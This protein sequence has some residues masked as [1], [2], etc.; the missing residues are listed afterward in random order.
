MNEIMI[1]NVRHGN[2]PTANVLYW[3]YVIGKCSLWGLYC[4]T[5]SVT[6]KSN[7]QQ[8]NWTKHCVCATHYSFCYVVNNIE[9]E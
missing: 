7:L 3:M 9:I 4:Y 8:Y 2:S 5:A 1:F 6:S